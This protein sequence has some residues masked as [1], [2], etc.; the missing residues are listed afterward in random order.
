MQS[1]TPLGGS[2]K[3]HV[4]NVV[5][6]NAASSFTSQD[7]CIVQVPQAQAQQLPQSQQMLMQSCDALISSN[8]QLLPSLLK[9]VAQSMQQDEGDGPQSSDQK[10]SQQQKAA[11]ALAKYQEF[12]RQQQMPPPQLNQ[13]A[14]S[15]NQTDATMASISQHTHQ[16]QP[17]A[18]ILLPS[19]HRSSDNNAS[20][21]L[22]LSRGDSLP[23]FSSPA[24]SQSLS[25]NQ[26]LFPASPFGTQAPASPVASR[27]PKVL[28]SGDGR[29]G[30]IVLPAVASTAVISHVTTVGKEAR[31]SV[32]S[33]TTRTKECASTD[34]CQTPESKHF[35]QGES[36]DA[37][38]Q[39]SAVSDE[40]QEETLVIPETPTGTPVQPNSNRVEDADV[41]GIGSRRPRPQPIRLADPTEA[42]QFKS[43]SKSSD[44]ASACTSASSAKS[45]RFV[46]SVCQSHA[47]SYLFCFRNAVYSKIVALPTQPAASG[48][49]FS[50][51]TSSRGRTIRPKVNFDSL[52]HNNIENVAVPPVRCSRFEKGTFNASLSSTNASASKPCDAGSSGDECEDDVPLVCPA[53]DCRRAMPCASVD[54]VTVSRNPTA[55]AKR[56]RTR[57]NEIAKMQI[58]SCKKL[59][60]S[61]EPDAHDTVMQSLE[62]RNMS[63]IVT[64][65]S[66]CL[67]FSQFD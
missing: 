10:Q 56:A 48:D 24:L 57:C 20:E 39:D 30:F 37:E 35:A 3:E 55:P 52:P 46:T 5:A 15:S 66:R 51:R 32:Q 42:P 2:S 41:S 65:V 47:C 45:R 1:L 8:Q 22:L 31:N 9:D 36:S 54:D 26:H 7:N 11:S 62:L 59:V 14:S 13:L 4:I 6:N 23:T 53:P 50:V 21:G 60:Q 34:Q 29:P 40:G 27:L 61:R 38:T 58:E 64:N 49:A 17:P 28:P 67:C 63:F 18:A 12:I 44:T 33:S 16:P 19:S 43:S 25:L